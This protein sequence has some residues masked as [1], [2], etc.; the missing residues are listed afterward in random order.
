MILADQRIEDVT[1]EVIVRKV[2]VIMRIGRRD[3]RAQGDAQVGGRTRDAHGYERDGNAW[4][5]TSY[6]EM[7]QPYSAGAMCSSKLTPDLSIPVFPLDVE[8]FIAPCCEVD[9][10]LHMT[11][12]SQRQEP[13][14]CDIECVRSVL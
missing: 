13:I 14:V 12:S 7:T 4:I 2:A 10:D 11:L 1:A 5:N 6:L 9:N 3:L 8:M